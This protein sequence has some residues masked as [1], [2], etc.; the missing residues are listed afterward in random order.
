MQRHT[1]TCD[2]RAVAGVVSSL[3]RA[4]HNPGIHAAVQSSFSLCEAD[5]FIKPGIA[6]VM[7]CRFQQQVPE[8]I[9]LVLF[10]QGKPFATAWASSASLQPRPMQSRPAQKSLANSYMSKWSCCPVLQLLFEKRNL[11]SAEINFRFE[12]IQWGLG[13]NSQRRHLTMLPLLEWSLALFSWSAGPIPK[14]K[15]KMQ[16]HKRGSYTYLINKSDVPWDLMVPYCRSLRHISVRP[17]L[18]C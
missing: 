6:E 3:Q 16:S 5:L 13:S 8:N 9:L 12:K 10:V 15:T 7:L 18:G 17:H 2:W 1:N 4:L 11:H 14:K